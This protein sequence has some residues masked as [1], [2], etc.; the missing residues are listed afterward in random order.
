MNVDSCNHNF[1]D[2]KGQ[3]ACVVSL[4]PVYTY[5]INWSFLLLLLIEKYKCEGIV[6]HLAKM[7]SS[8]VMARVTKTHL[9]HLN[10]VCLFHSWFI[11][12]PVQRSSL[13]FLWLPQLL[14]L[15]FWGFYYILWLLIVTA[16]PWWLVLLHLVKK[17]W[18]WPLIRAVWKI[19]EGSLLTTS[20]G[21][22]GTR[23]KFILPSGGTGLSLPPP[24]HWGQNFPSPLTLQLFCDSRHRLLNIPCWAP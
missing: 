17:G 19:S 6:F 15:G 11:F 9:S 7:V 4:S 14:Q 20:K 12:F 21:R 22:W 5:D 8:L 18:S 1:E 24:V 10:K 23:L 2:L 13:F 16:L 3:S